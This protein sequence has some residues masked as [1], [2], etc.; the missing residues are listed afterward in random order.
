MM[1]YENRVS[2]YQDIRGSE[3]SLDRSSKQGL[4]TLLYNLNKD[5]GSGIPY[6]L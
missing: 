2:E 6:G 1:M 5:P 3:R 4:K